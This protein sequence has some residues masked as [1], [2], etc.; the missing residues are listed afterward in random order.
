MIIKYIIICFLCSFVFSSQIYKEIRIDNPNSEIVHILNQNGVH[1]DHAHFSKGE[2]LIF[3]ASSNDIN[4]MNSLNIDY[5]ILVDDLEFFYQSRLTDNYTR[6]FGLGSMGGYYT[7]EEIEQNLDDLYNQYPQFVKEKI[8]IGTTLEGR[9]IWAIKLSDNPNID[10]DESEV[11]Y[12]GLHHA[13]EPM[14][15]MNLF[16]Y[17]HW[18]CENYGIEEKATEILNTRELWF[19]PAINPDGLVYNESIAPNGGGLQRKNGR[20]TCSSTPDGVDLNRNYSFQWGLDDQGSSGD[21]CSETYRGSSPFSEPESQ[22]VRDFVE[23]HDFPIA[24]NYHSYSDLLI[25]PFGYSY[26]ND[27]PAED[28]NTFI[29][30]GQEMVK[31]NGYALG[32]GPEL[33]YPVNGEACDWMYGEHQIF[34]YTPEIGG[35]SDGFWP[36]TDRIVPLAE[37]NLHPNQ[38]LSIHAG[39]V[40]SAELETLEGPYLQGETYPLY[41]LIEN[42]GLSE[43]RGNT[44]VSFS[45]SDLNLDL[46]S[47]DIS[48][49]DGRSEIDFGEFGAFSVPQNI[50]NGTVA[51]INIQVSNSDEICKDT[52]LE[53][54]IGEP[55]IL[56]EDDFESDSGWVVES[57][58]SAGLWERAIPNATFY[59]GQDVQPGYDHSSDGDY[60]FVTG[61]GVSNSVGFDDV[62]A[63]STILYSPIYDLSDYSTFIVSYWRWYTNNVGDNPGNDLWKVEISNNGGNSWSSLEVT[64]QTDNF[65]KNIQLV[66]NSDLFDFTDQMQFRFIAEDIQYPGDSGSGGSIVE[67]A[68]DDFSILV[69]E[70]S[71]TIPGDINY[72]LAVDVLDVVLI[73]NFIL[74]TQ[75]PSGSQFDSSDLNNDGVLNVVDIVSLI[76]IILDL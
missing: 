37:E 2:Y 56:I 26:E 62:D 10:E 63:G 16:Y 44:T 49:I 9:D 11:L 52:T 41:L 76:N 3:V 17:M 61:N 29:E 12:T 48:S 51:F 18:L 75:T 25:Y 42:I 38:F 39:A 1:I 33:L 74:D 13:R 64:S 43:S 73:V 34:A 19:I 7:F 67:A 35:Q 70:Q 59:E 22:A 72:D 71:N 57:S 50:D 27:V 40:I 54:L 15:Y 36:A 6:E 58:S 60:C 28:L 14:S 32:T 55:E 46:E 8:S 31:Y 47:L 68:L 65:W 21:G 5:D 4:I 24:L 20:Q 30:Y 66:M 45:S 53:I 23:S 69:F